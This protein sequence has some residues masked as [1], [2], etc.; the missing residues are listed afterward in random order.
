MDKLKQLME[1]L[2]KAQHDMGQVFEEAG[3]DLDFSKVKC[4]GGT[5]AE[6]SAALRKMNDD[7]AGIQKEVEAHQLVMKARAEFE[8][9]EKAGPMNHPEP[10]TRREREDIKDAKPMGLGEAIMKSG[11]LLKNNRHLS[12]TLPEGV[13]LKTTMTRSAGFDPFDA[14]LGRIVEYATRPILVMDLIPHGATAY[15][16]IKYMEETTFTNA[17]VGL[18]E[19]TT[20]HGEG[21]FAFTERSVTVERLGAYLPT[22]DEQL[23]DVPFIQG[24]IDRR[25][26]FAIMQYLDGQAV[27]GTGSTPAVLGIL[28]KG[29]IG[30]KNKTDT[31]GDLACDAIRRA[32]TAVRVTGRAVPSGIIMNPYDWDDI[33][34][35]KT[36]DGIYIWGPPSEAGPE[37]IWG[38]PVAQSD[39]IAQYKAVVGDFANY[40]EFVERR[41]IEVKITDSHDTN[42][43]YGRQAIRADIR[44]AFVWYRAAA[45]C[46][47]NLNS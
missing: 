22:T 33:R 21:A 14:R 18:T 17:T 1:R 16:T 41:G 9:R 31:A 8:A 34:L 47:V 44:G 5:D 32:M 43:I 30:S 6:K 45:F 3:T 24:Y 36:T 37:R 39:A 2:T 20:A 10:N 28:N 26:R 13:T 27:N 12:F 4:I 25:L 42:F 23:E 15:S 40:S 7:C 19:N 38:V 46:E 11:V 29:S 35:M